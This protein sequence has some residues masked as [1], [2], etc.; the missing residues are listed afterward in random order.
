MALY[1]SSYATNGANTNFMT[2]TTSTGQIIATGPAPSQP[3]HALVWNNGA[4]TG[5]WNTSDA[6]WN[7][8]TMVW[9]NSG[10]DN[11][12]FTNTGI[13]TV[14]LTTPITAG[15]L[16]FESPGYTITGST[17][18][19]SGTSAITNDADATIASAIIS[20][21][22]NK[23][24]LG[25]LT[26]SGANTYSG[27]S[28][29]NAGTLQLGSSSALPGTG[30]TLGSG[31]NTT[32]LDL[33]GFNGTVAAL[34]GGANAIVDNLSGGSSTL[35][36]GN[37]GASG[38]FS[39][40]IQNTAGTVSLDI[41]SAGTLVLGS[42]AS[43]GSAINVSIE[44]GATLDVSAL[45]GNYTLGSSATLT[46]SGTASPATIKGPSGG[47]VNLGAQPIVLNYDGADPALTVS[48]STLNLNGN[49][50][51]V[52]APFT[53]V[54]GTYPLIQVTGGGSIVTNGSFT[55][56]GTAIARGYAAT[57][58]V[59][60]S[61][62]MINVVRFTLSTTT[63]MGPFA[64][65]QTYGSV[66]LGATVSPTNATGT[67][68]FYSGV[69]NVGTATLIN[70]TATGPAIQNLLP[71]GSHPITASYGGD[72]YYAGS[73]SASSSNLTVTGRT[74]TL[75]GSKPYDKTAVITPA[76]GLTIAPNFDGA[77]VYLSPPGASSVW[78]AGMPGRKPS[79][80][81]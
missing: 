44:A 73:S 61:Q 78:P 62:L 72:L 15:F 34:T 66:I 37:N 56:N 31:A 51:S 25:T 41:L 20:G 38:T 71:V 12:I 68:T 57:L 28:T 7:V 52:N 54:A 43:L 11:A 32:T 46:A 39:G 30:L 22:V 50:I 81:S 70:G 21:V 42:G 75:A 13:G 17:L 1:T 80:P 16:D 48:Q 33:H 27:A 19:L 58:L 79:P 26:L 59:S 60:G 9:N 5:H 18:A 4:V 63:T 64:P 55:V 29:V 67:V 3:P 35:S 14:T 24:G 23:W 45:A 8:G 6:N 40:V 77:N 74:V 76:T 10:P 53:L 36:V 49:T 69:T 47:T 2:Q 65:S